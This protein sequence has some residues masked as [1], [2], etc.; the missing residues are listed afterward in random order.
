M[1]RHV[2]QMILHVRL[3]PKHACSPVQTAL[4]SDSGKSK[5]CF[6]QGKGTGYEALLSSFH[7]KILNMAN[8]FITSW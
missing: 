7:G 3:N 6:Q 8:V 1:L 5:K 4:L 2:A